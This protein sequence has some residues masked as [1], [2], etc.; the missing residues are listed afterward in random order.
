MLETFLKYL[1]ISMAVF[2]VVMFSGAFAVLV[3]MI[4]G[5][6]MRHV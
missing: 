5:A 3:M 2:Y 1:F 6:F 4:I